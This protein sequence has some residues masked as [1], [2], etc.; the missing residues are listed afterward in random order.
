VTDN[1]LPESHHHGPPTVPIRAADL[2]NGHDSS[3]RTP[4]SS[5]ADELDD[6]CRVDI[7]SSTNKSDRSNQPDISGADRAKQHADRDPDQTVEQSTSGEHEAI[8]S[9]VIRSAPPDTHVDLD[10]ADT[11]INLDQSTDMW[12]DLGHA[13]RRF[14]RDPGP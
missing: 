11:D 6:F 3:I 12:V 1:E 4:N 8:P 14:R 13:L 7:V 2:L 10:P 9:N 5:Y